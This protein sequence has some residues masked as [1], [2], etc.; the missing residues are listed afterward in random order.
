M[1]S[2]N[3]MRLKLLLEDDLLLQQ[4]LSQCESPDQVIAVCAKLQL[5]I[6]MADLLR[7][8]AQMTL[9]LNDEQ[10]NTWYETPYWKR[11]LISLGAIQPTEQCL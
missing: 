4:Q 10:L 5:Q 6:S 2:A 9:T 11:V 1:T 7:M 3:A 8:E